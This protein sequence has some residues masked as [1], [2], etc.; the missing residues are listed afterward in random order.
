MKKPMKDSPTYLEAFLGG[1][2]AMAFA[3]KAEGGSIPKTFNPYEAYSAW[4]K[5]A[6]GEFHQQ[7]SVGEEFGK[8]SYPGVYLRKKE[9]KT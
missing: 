2:N 8:V 5:T 4:S 1:V 9:V 3:I 6:R 7:E